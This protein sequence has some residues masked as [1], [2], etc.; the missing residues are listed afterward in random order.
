MEALFGKILFPID[1]D[2]ISI[3]AIELVRKLAKQNNATVYLLYAIPKSPAPES[4]VKQFATDQLR[5]IAHKW[6]VS[7]TRHEVVIRSGEPAA[8]IVKAAEELGVDVIVMATHGR[9]GEHHARLGSVTEQVVRE[10]RCPVITI[11]PR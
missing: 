1:F 9:T 11:R 2:R 6:L 8:A 3:P 10:S 4:D 5:A 7:H